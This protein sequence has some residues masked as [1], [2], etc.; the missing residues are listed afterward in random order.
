MKI[1]IEKGERDRDRLDRMLEACGIIIRDAELH[2][3]LTPST[4]QRVKIAAKNS[5]LDEYVWEVESLRAERDKLRV[6]LG[7][8]GREDCI[9]C[10]GIGWT[11]S[12]Q[13]G[14]ASTAIGADRVE[15]E[16]RKEMQGASHAD[17]GK[18]R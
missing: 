1:Q 15:C 5:G 17:T 13:Y 4:I 6:A 18:S 14:T 2:G 8:R 3:Y 10:H 11:C 16:C 9:H 12:G 7:S